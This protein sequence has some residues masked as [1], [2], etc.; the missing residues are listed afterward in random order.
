MAVNINISKK[1]VIWN[2]ISKFFQIGTGFITLPLI[3]HFLTAE[4]IGMNYLMLTV[5]S[6]V[7]LLDFGFG[8]QFGRNF[9]YVNSGAQSL[10][11]E[12]IEE[13]KDGDI[14]YHLLSVLLKTAKFVYIRLSLIALLAMVSLGSI[15]IYYVTDGFTNVNGALAIWLLFSF[16]TFFNIYYS[17]Y[18][19]LLTGSGMIK[20]SAIATIFSK[21]TYIMICIVLLLLKFGLISVILANLISPFIQRYY[22]YKVYYTTDLKSKLTTSIP[23]QDIKET[24]NLIWH[25]AKR[26]G[27]NF[28]GSYAINKFGFF[29]IG[30]YLPLSAI[31]SYGLL[32]QLA[33]ILQGVATTL[34]LTYQPKFANYRITGQNLEFKKLVSLT[35]MCYFIFMIIGSLLLIYVAPYILNIIHSKTS[36]PISGICALYLFV[37]I[38]EGNHSLFATLIVT[39]NKVP[40]V[41]AALIS[42]GIIVLLTFFVLQFTNWNLWGVILVQGAVQLSYNN[43]R[44]PL[45]IFKD[46][47]LSIGEYFK[48]GYETVSEKLTKHEIRCK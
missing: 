3:L 44:W 4:E 25:N 19:S 38:L 16:S 41:S 31:G 7:A 43:W 39:K 15:Y 11:K 28:I 48:L 1:D 46:V 36:L 6:I 10:L 40:F 5:S 35:S 9:S 34:F 37:I 21:G 2:Y 45:W 23:Y 8:P 13:N 24:F 42:G 27:V 47:N 14:N 26:L 33:S 20:E 22:S 12:G 17:F 32:I 18:N 30:L 29:L